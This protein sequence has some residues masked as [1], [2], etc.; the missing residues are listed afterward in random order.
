MGQAFLSAGYED[1][2]KDSLGK[3]AFILQRQFKGYENNNPAEK[4]QKALPFELIQCMTQ[5]WSKDPMKIRFHILILVA[6][7]FAMRSCEYLRVSGSCRTQPIHLCNIVFRDYKSWIIR[8]DSPIL[9]KA[10][11]VLITYRFQKKD[12]RDDTI[13][14]SRSGHSL[15][16]PVQACAALVRQMLADK[17]KPTDPIYKFRQ[18]NG[19]MADL[20]SKMALLML[21]NFVKTCGDEFNIKHDEIGLHSMR[22]ASAMAMYLNGIP[23]YTIMLL[24]RWSS[25]AFLRYIRKQVTEFSRN[26]SRKMI[27]CPVFY[28]TNHAE[29]EDPRSHN[30]RA[31]AANQGMGTHGHDNTR[32]AF[33]VWG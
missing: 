32:G 17:N 31:A 5:R 24:G 4:P 7:F 28:Y 13:T 29:T 26:V 14:Q 8:H 30:P 23:V 10:K 15:F 27:H 33:A 12:L 25:D 16:C 19:A 21:R 11:S 20:H 1:S 9:H 2:G 3:T 6:F 22:S 18:E